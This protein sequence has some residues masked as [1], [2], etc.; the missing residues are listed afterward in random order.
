MQVV[1]AHRKR[2]AEYYQ[3]HR[4]EIL[5]KRR[6]ASRISSAERKARKAA[7]IAADHPLR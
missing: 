7:G 5:L 1:L 3:N 6:Q 2:A 4:E